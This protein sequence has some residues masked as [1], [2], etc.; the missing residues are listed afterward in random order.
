MKIDK[1][2]FLA[3]A[4]EMDVVKHIL[5]VIE[6]INSFNDIDAILDRILLEARKLTNADAGTI[7]WCIRAAWSLFMCI[8]RPCFRLIATT[9][10]Y[11][12]D[13]RF[14]LIRTLLWGM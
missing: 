6:E 2:A 4:E 3:E 5:E 9:G 1:S 13:S 10:T 7:F 14:P 12:A 11:T 8:M